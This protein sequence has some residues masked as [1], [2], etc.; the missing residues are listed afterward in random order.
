MRAPRF[1]AIGVQMERVLADFEAALARDP[2]LPFFDLGVVEF[3]DAPALQ[4]HEM[5]VMR[6]LIQLEYGFAGFEMMADQ[7][8]C[9]LELRQHAV[10]GGQTDIE[11][12]RDQQP[13]DILGRQVSHLR[14]LEQIDDPKPRQ[15]GFEAGV[16]EIVGGTHRRVAI[17]V[18]V[19]IAVAL[20]ISGRS[21]SIK[22]RSLPGHYLQSGGNAVCK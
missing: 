7:K 2:Y 14:R 9:L 19:I 12:F 3:L 5:V 6:T 16:L 17:G 13:I 10:D 22:C 18:A 20:V 21:V 11:P 1:G 8:T 15:R 4:A